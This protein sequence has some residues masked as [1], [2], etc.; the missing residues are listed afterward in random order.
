MRDWLQKARQDKSLTQQQLA[1]KLGISES[2][3]AY[4]ESGA[5]QKKLDLATASKLSSI[6]GLSI[7][8]IVKYES[9]C[10]QH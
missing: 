4:I 3:Y 2:Y 1:E 10:N 9:P 6:L 8:Q 7:Q 5:R